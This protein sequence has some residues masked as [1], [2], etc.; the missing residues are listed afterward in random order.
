MIPRR[1]IAASLAVV[2][3]VT[4]SCLLLVQLAFVTGG[5]HWARHSLA[6]TVAL[7]GLAAMLAIFFLG[8]LLIDL[9]IPETLN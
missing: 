9:G 5:H 1:L 7:I 8:R 4:V 3:S 6:G 2:L